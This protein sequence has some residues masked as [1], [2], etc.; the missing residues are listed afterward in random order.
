MSST[1][2]QRS[3]NVFLPRQ[4]PSESAQPAAAATSTTSRPGH[5]ND[6]AIAVPAAAGSIIVLMLLSWAVVVLTKRRRRRELSISAAGANEAQDA[7]DHASQRR[8]TTAAG[9]TAS[10]AEGGSVRMLLFHLFG[11][12]DPRAQASRNTAQAS[13]ETPEERTR[14]RDE[15]RAMRLRRTDSGH[16]VKT[17]PVYQEEVGEGELVL[18]KA[19]GS[20]SQ[21][22]LT[23]M[24]TR[25][26]ASDAWDRGHERAASLPLLGGQTSA[27]HSRTN[28]RRS[29]IGDVRASLRRS[30]VGSPRRDSVRA[31]QAS[32][33]DAEATTDSNEMES[34]N[35]VAAS[36]S[37]DTLDETLPLER[38]LD[39]EE[40]ERERS[41]T[42]EV[43]LDDTPDYTSLYPSVH[44]VA[45][46]RQ[47]P[48]PV[49]ESAA[50][51]RSGLRSIFDP[52]RLTFHVTSPAGRSRGAEG[53]PEADL[54]VAPSQRAVLPMH[55]RRMASHASVFS[56][57]TGFTD[58]RSLSLHPTQSRSSVAPGSASPSGHHRH[59]STPSSYQSAFRNDDGRLSFSHSVVSLAQ[60]SLSDLSGTAVPR[61]RGQAIS[62]PV[63][64]SVIRTSFLNFG[65]PTGPD[66]HRARP[67]PEQL[68]FLS[69]VES[70]GRYGVPLSGPSGGETEAPP[71]AW[72][73]LGLRADD[74]TS[75]AS[76]APNVDDS[77][78]L[79]PCARAPPPLL[80]SSE[81]A[82]R[83]E[84][85]Q[86][87]EGGYAISPIGPEPASAAPAE[88]AAQSADAQVD[89]QPSG[90]T[91]DE[92]PASMPS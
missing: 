87:R 67:T 58:G 12:S 15:R 81:I 30:L 31:R 69:S 40:E 57:L 23:P 10:R 46:S 45:E 75:S 56:T 5:A 50:P 90:P 35:P 84:Q 89:Q 64:G 24:P 92:N 33:G 53:V 11:G 54:G 32:S 78:A 41:D 83:E 52:R 49:T 3:T 37:M 1:A 70:L 73:S 34:L 63:E 29:V 43:P 13:A 9:G 44:A 68:R 91:E 27:P 21:L 86:R 80:L 48:V 2:L 28:S 4:Q 47:S 42:A 36:T 51:R 8:P 38:S 16:S 19:E 71:P 26:S 77:A 72:E 20:G 18:Y 60:P 17:I 7:A 74:A 55:H 88:G 39:E 65:T 6:L 82:V 22:N 61:V 14:R 79:Q 66:G 76:A 25:G 85:E 59:G 62:G